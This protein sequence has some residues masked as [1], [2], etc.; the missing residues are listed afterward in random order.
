MSMNEALSRRLFEMSRLMELLG[1]DSF[2][3]SAHARAA[4]A[5][6]A[7]TDDVAEVAADRARL[8]AIDGLGP[9]TADKV[10]EFVRTGAIAE[11]AEFL[12]RVP[13]GLPELMDIPGLGPKTLR[14]IWQ[15]AGVTDLSSL[16]KALA[17]GTLVGLPRLGEKSVEKI[18]QSVEFYVSQR[19][20]GADGTG[21]LPLGV[22]MPIA[23]RVVSYLGSVAT[24]ATIAFA[25]SLRRGKETIGDID[26]LAAPRTADEGKALT[27][28]FTSMP[29]VVGIISSG[30]TRS[31]VRVA[32]VEASSR[33]GI[34][35]SR[36]SVGVQMDLKIV[37]PDSW[38]AA[39]M[40]FTGSK[41]HN[42]AM[43]ERARARGMTL[44][45]YGLFPDDDPD[46]KKKPPHN[47]GVVPIASKSESE[48]FAALGLAYLPPECREDQGELALAGT[49]E[50]IRIEDIRAE[51]HA[52]TT[53]SDGR[54][55]II[56]LVERA[57]ERGLHVIAVTDHSRS[58]AV[59]GGLSIERLVEHVEA[60][61]EVASKVEGITVLAGSEVDI[62]ADGSLD[63]PD[64]VLGWLDV[65]VASPHAALSQDPQTAT[66]RLVR[67]IR[68]PMVNVLGHPTGRQIL[69]RP[70]LPADMAAV[71][72]A[73]RECG[74]ALEINTH[75]IRLDLRDTHVRG[76]VEAG[77]LL[78]INSDVHE[79]SDFENLRYGVMTARRG[80]LA[81]D[82]C[83]NAWPR[84]RLLEWLGSKRGGRRVPSAGPIARGRP[85]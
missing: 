33:W 18:R 49:P 57:K 64:D 13:P 42:V 8:L 76:A 59:A 56:E 60:V 78:A 2:R 40:Y 26:I 45:E 41:E 53:A 62:L 5:V 19:A 21:R 71:Y 52:H 70:G 4:R 6:E 1:E 11:H 74:V 54:L 65:V 50:L 77:C 61:R 68:H 24:G 73:A 58:S 36:A 44:N 35:P 85:L 39:M 79:A 51:L 17:E 10:I 80:G 75:W 55:S 23:E 15:S 38:G 22:A 82:R 31:S 72:A 29:G 69:R 46:G 32:P 48:V 37:P 3:A 27:A 16:R 34:D 66:R 81:A 25:G 7:M 12:S 63:Y 47:R 83:V 30:P 20:S 67:A 9:K 14:L 28:A 84:E 43:R